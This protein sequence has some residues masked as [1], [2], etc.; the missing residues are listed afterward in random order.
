MHCP[1]CNHPETKVNDTRLA[2]DGAQVRRR[3]ECLMCTERFTTF[4]TAELV[5]PQV[6]KND[7]SREPYQAV[8]LRVGMMSALQKRPVSQEAM[9]AAINKIEM[10]LRNLGEREVTSRAIGELVM[11]ELRSLDE[12]AYVRFASI[13]RSFEGVGDFKTEI[14]RMSKPSKV[15]SHIG[16]ISTSKNS[17]V[18]QLSF[19]DSQASQGGQSTVDASTP[20]KGK[21]S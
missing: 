14:N 21:P 19:L 4:E 16:K 9:D 11:L 2:A 8:K 18:D 1:F 7:Q 17:K 10:K 12:V 13:Y 3:R 20:D 5:M 6:I 15:D